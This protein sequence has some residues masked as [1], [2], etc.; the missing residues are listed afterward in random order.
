MSLKARELMK[1]FRDAGWVLDRIR[2]SH[3]IFTKKGQAFS[4]PGPASREVSPGVSNAALKKIEE[5]G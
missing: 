1:K 2:G 5:V 3:H 4:V